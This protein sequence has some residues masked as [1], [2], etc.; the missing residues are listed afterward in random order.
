MI[1][2]LIFSSSIFLYSLNCVEELTRATTKKLNQGMAEHN[3]A[4]ASAT[5]DDAKAS[6]V[7]ELRTK[8]PFS[9]NFCVFFFFFLIEFS[10]YPLMNFQKI[11]KQNT[12]SGLRTCNNILAM[13]QVSN[14]TLLTF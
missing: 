9:L 12:T 5:S 7:S 13:T 2:S 11:Q 4:L 14:S 1:F 8:F 10:G 6:I 3:K